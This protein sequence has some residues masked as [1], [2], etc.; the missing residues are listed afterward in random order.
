MISLELLASKTLNEFSD[1][2]DAHENIISDLLKID[3]LIKAFP[4]YKGTVKS[5]GAWGG[6]FFLAIGPEDSLE[7]FENRNLKIGFRF[8]D[9]IL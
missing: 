2:V 6:D 8:K 1:L 4:D 5:L 9:F 3:P 7:Y